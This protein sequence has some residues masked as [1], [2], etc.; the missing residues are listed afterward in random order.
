MHK[1]SAHLVAIVFAVA[2]VEA[3]AADRPQS[4]CVQASQA[5]T[6]A[7]S[8]PRQTVDGAS[9][10]GAAAVS[11]VGNLA[12][13]AGGGA[14]AASYA[15]VNAPPSGMPN[16]ISMNVTVPKQTQG[17]TFGEKVN[18]GLHAAGG[19]LGQAASVAPG[20][21]AG[22]DE[23]TATA[24]KEKRGQSDASAGAGAAVAASEKASATAPVGKSENK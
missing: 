2:C 8:G 14:A 13:G 23:E 15:K 17:A 16:R 10:E 5:P 12:G 18:Q 24:L 20:A 7:K 6:T 11:S 1:L 21:T 19:A 4:T 3:R 9:A 22:C